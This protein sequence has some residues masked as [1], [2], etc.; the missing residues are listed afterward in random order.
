MSDVHLR[1]NPLTSPPQ[2]PER[3]FT[4]WHPISSDFEN[5]PNLVDNT[6]E[7]IWSLIGTG[8]NEKSTI[9]APIDGQSTTAK[10][11]FDIPLAY[12]MQRITH[13]NFSAVKTRNHKRTFWGL[14]TCF[15][16]N[17]QRPPGNRRKRSA[18]CRNNQLC[19]TFRH[20][21]WRL[22][23]KTLEERHPESRKRKD[24]NV[25]VASCKGQFLLT[26]TN[27]SVLVF[28]TA[29]DRH[30]VATKGFREQAR[31]ATTRKMKWRLRRRVH[32]LPS[33]DVCQCVHAIQVVH[34]DSAR[35]TEVRRKRYVESSV[36]IEKRGVVTIQ[37]HTLLIGQHHQ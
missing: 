9:A 17:I 29:A 19:A 7:Q 26:R 3:L 37:W 12:I 24:L 14:C 10:A 16:S 18:S 31:T 32:S 8:S 36:P 33:S 27:T 1:Q 23:K 11:K 2:S 4:K 15:R 22:G 35:D 13:E 30:N 5:L 28:W 20:T 6:A 34:E 25:A 21:H